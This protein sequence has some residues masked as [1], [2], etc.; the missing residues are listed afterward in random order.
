MISK[1][2][3]CGANL[4]KLLPYRARVALGPRF[5]HHARKNHSAFY[6]KQE[7]TGGQEDVSYELQAIITHKGKDAEYGHY[8]AHKKHV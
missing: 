4:A 7:E 6:F 3:P 2:N 8:V 5:R 1:K